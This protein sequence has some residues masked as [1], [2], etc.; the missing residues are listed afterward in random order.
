MSIHS[1]EICR[2]CGNAFVYISGTKI[3][4]KCFNEIERIY[5]IGRSDLK[6][7][8]NEKNPDIDTLARKLKTSP[9]FIDLILKDSISEFE[10]IYKNQTKTT[11][12][13]MFALELTK[14]AKC[15]KLNKGC[16]SYSSR[17]SQIPPKTELQEKVKYKEVYSPNSQKKS[18]LIAA[19]SNNR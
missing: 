4:Y 7:L 5:Q 19:K 11:I 10:W 12:L 13:A 2:T 3:C 9:I 6:K 18:I 14:M 16:I 1:I 15:N 17:M 8:R